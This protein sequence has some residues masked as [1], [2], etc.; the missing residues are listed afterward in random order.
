MGIANPTATLLSAVM[1]LDHLDLKEDARHLESAVYQ[2]LNEGV[3][4]SDVGGSFG[5]MDFCH[6]LILNLGK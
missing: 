2:T 5:T 4:T 3:R 1:M 6:E